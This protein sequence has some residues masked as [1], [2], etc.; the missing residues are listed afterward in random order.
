M[1]YLGMC[2]MFFIST[3]NIFG[4]ENTSKDKDVFFIQ[5]LTFEQQEEI[6]KMRTEFLECFSE[7]KN[8][9][10]S[11][12]METQNE[13]RKENPDWNEIKKLNKEYSTIQK[14]LNQGMSDYKEKVQSIHVDIVN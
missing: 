1:K 14:V 9:L 2:T 4:D 8:K 3:L 10:V 7:M 13:M 11:I 6:V 5:C 12:K